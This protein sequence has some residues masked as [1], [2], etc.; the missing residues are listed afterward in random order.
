VVD[1]SS[2][3]PSEMARLLGKPEGEAGI[4]ISERLNQVNAAITSAVYRSLQLRR[5]D[6]VLEI[7]FGNGKLLPQLLAHADDMSYL[8][9]DIADT[10]V[11]AAKTANA[12]LVRS[13]RAAFELASAEEIPR[14]DASFH[15]VF[16]VN[17]I[18]FWPDPVRAL[19]EL[20]RVLSPDG[21]SVVAAI[22]PGPEDTPPPF[23]RDEFGFRVRD[24]E[25]VVA[26]HRQAGFGNVELEDY[27]EI[28][29]RPD[30][31][32]WKRRYAIVSAQP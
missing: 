26:L 2:L 11:E 30:G 20:R 12:D 14:P 10:M 27:E 9:I 19:A 1:I 15:R 13:G 8:G 16:A 3:P 23:V 25:T 17:V 28:A 29:K 22:N 5:G 7:G 32:P 18:Y 4:A 24:A 31:T 21:L 6:R